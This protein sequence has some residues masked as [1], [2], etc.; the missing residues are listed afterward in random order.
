VTNPIKSSAATRQRRVT[1][2]IYA[3]PTNAPSFRPP[4][5]E[6]PPDP[7]PLYPTDWSYR[8]S[9]NDSAT[10]WK[11]T[12]RTMP[13]SVGD[14]VQAW[15][16]LG[17]VSDSDYLEYSTT[18]P[19]L[20]DLTTRKVLRWASGGG[21]LFAKA[22]DGGNNLKTSMPGSNADFTAW[23]VVSSLTDGSG[24]SLYIWGDAVGASRM[25]IGIK[26]TSGTYRHYTNSASVSLYWADLTDPAIVFAW[27]DG[28]TMRLQVNNGTPVT[29]VQGTN[30]VGGTWWQ[31]STKV[32]YSQKAFDVSD[33]GLFSR[34]L[35]DTE[36]GELYTQLA[37][38]YGL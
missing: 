28:T 9:V 34:A 30:P 20:T 33:I 18:A 38:E 21:H 10:L 25:T 14:S 29:S 37:T 16:H 26:S 11:D 6:P 8:Y 7:T 35:S 31:Y 2:A 5:P 23:Y 32:N 15:D 13:A 19:V 36:R 3:A 24:Q 17:S 27:Y 4:P 1:T 22:Y 12:T